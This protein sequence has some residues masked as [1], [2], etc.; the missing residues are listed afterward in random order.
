MIIRSQAKSYFTGENP[1]DK[2]ANE[3][4][5]LCNRKIPNNALVL[6]HTTTKSIICL[7]CLVDIAELS[8]IHQ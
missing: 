3:K 4:C 6:R 8:E 5:R 1:D 2:I 7:L